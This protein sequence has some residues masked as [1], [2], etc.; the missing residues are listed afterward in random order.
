MRYKDDPDF[1]FPVYKAVSKRILDFGLTRPQLGVIGVM[2]F[3][4]MVL[5]QQ[6]WSIAIVVLLVIV[7]K[8]LNK[9]DSFYLDKIINAS[10]NP[11]KL[12]H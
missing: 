8:Q 11:D 6:V 3:I 10:V 12:E 4:M 5:F 7:F 1:R 2:T 9:K